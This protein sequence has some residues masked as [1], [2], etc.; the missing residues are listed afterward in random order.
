MTKICGKTEGEVSAGWGRRPFGEVMSWSCCFSLPV[1]LSLPLVHSPPEPYCPLSPTI[2]VFPRHCPPLIL[3]PSTENRLER[4][5]RGLVGPPTLRVFPEGHTPWF[6]FFLWIT[7]VKYL[8]LIS[9]WAIFLVFLH[10]ILL[11][12]HKICM[13]PK[14]TLNGYTQGPVAFILYPPPCLPLL[15][16]GN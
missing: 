13:I 9:A 3:Y 5:G 12:E 15:S 2:P 10:L 4:T 8:L 6:D 14:S 11:F 16:A 7:S 1:L